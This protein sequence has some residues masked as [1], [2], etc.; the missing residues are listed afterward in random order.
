MSDPSV[1]LE[2]QGILLLRTAQ[3]ETGS[4]ASTWQLLGLVCICAGVL[5]VLL[6]SC[7]RVD[8]VGEHLLE[9]SFVPSGGLVSSCYL[10]YLQHMRH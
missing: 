10:L 6:D 7:W 4:G 1:R 3:T 8:I 2:L 9:V 5:E